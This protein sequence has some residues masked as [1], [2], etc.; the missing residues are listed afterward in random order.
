MTYIFSGK[1]RCSGQIV[2]SRLPQAHP[3]REGFFSD[4]QPSHREQQSRASG[5]GANRGHE[6]L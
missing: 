1:S 4:G 3:E 5:R 6:G 2:Q